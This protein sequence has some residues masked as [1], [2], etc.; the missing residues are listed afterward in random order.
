MLAVRLADG[1]RRFPTPLATPY[2]C[3]NTPVML[4]DTLLLKRCWQVVLTMDITTGEIRKLG[5]THQLVRVDEYTYAAVG[6]RRTYYGAVADDLV[7]KDLAS[8][9][10]AAHVNNVY[11]HAVASWQHPPD[12]AN[13]YLTAPGPGDGNTGYAGT[14]VPYGGKIVWPPISG[15]IRSRGVP[16]SDAGLPR[17][18]C[19]RGH[20]FPREAFL[21]TGLLFVLG[22]GAGVVTVCRNRPPWMGR[23]PGKGA[24]GT[25]G[26]PCITCSDMLCACRACR[27]SCGPLRGALP[28][29]P[30]SP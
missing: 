18:V 16:G 27:G 24:A 17:R 8:P 13:R 5:D 29:K 26:Q 20:V 7:V 10:N 12:R 11:T 15:A 1:T 6:G 19:R 9:R 23:L 2:W 14:P 28:A 22:I 3:I 25:G 21:L 4:T 30:A